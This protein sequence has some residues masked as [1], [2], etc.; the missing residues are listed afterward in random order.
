MSRYLRWIGRCCIFCLFFQVSLAQA[1]VPLANMVSS[2]QVQA[3]DL[4]LASDET[5]L[6]LL[7]YKREMLS[8]RFISQADDDEFF[9]DK[10]GRFDAAAELRAAIRA[11]LSP[12]TETGVHAQCLFPARWWW[13]KQQLSIIENVDVSCVKLDAFMKSFSHDS[14]FLVFPSMYLNNPGSS[15][16]HTFLRFDDDSD[17][18]L[19]SQTLNYAAR[20]DPDDA[21]IS[22]IGKGIFGGYTGFFR[23]RRYYETVQEYNN[24]ENRDIWEYQLNFSHAEIQQLVRHVWEVKGIDFDYYF[25]RENCAYRLLAL[26]DVMRPG[27]QLTGEYDFPLYAI[28]VDT[29]RAL[30]AA[31]LVQSRT[32]R[33]SLA[34]QINAQ[35]AEIDSHQSSLVLEIVAL[36]QID[37]Q[38]LAEKLQLFASAEEQGD[39]LSQSYRILQF[40]G[41]SSSTLAQTILQLMHEMSRL[42]VDRRLENKK[43]KITDAVSP[44]M[45]SPDKGHRSTRLG[46]G[47]GRQNSLSYIKLKFRPAF[48]DLLDDGRGY[49]NGAAINVLAMELKWFNANPSVDNLRL[50]KL[51]LFNVTSLSPLS[52]WQKPISWMLDFRF[53]RTQLSQSRS[54]SNFISRGGAGYS[55]DKY[56][57]S[58]YLMLMAEWNLASAYDK[59]YSLLLGVQAGIRL[60]L[61]VNQLMLSYQ[62]DNAVSG[63]DMER[64]VTLL[65]LQHNFQQNHALR[66][67]YRYTDY[68]FFNDE[69]WSLDYHYYF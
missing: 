3:E 21:L 14:L 62:A 41:R 58:P 64:R 61:Q 23:A 43:V 52:S 69:D 37:K 49:L 38:L 16:G 10:N 65:Q 48:H 44:A 50:E 47:F 46:T 39:V 6:A 13:L 59:G 35:F 45:I 20:V 68:P 24:I 19:L 8:R 34:T 51:S 66:L 5:W 33:P 4:Q 1:V 31:G 32:F 22:Y 63:F 12:V 57:L 30:D 28:P 36:E 15:F 27:L 29:V 18:I 7:H 42:P 55:V 40:N 25:L 9:L 67:N 56:G 11:F 54:V 53:D 26:L 2:L 17:S 60:T